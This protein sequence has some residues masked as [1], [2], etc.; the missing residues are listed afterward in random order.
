MKEVK[1]GDLFRAFGLVFEVKPS[2][3]PGFFYAE[4]I[5]GKNVSF[6]RLKKE[7]AE[8]LD[9]VDKFNTRFKADQIA[10]LRSLSKTGITL[11]EATNRLIEAGSEVA[12]TEEEDEY[13]Y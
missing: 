5:S 8:K 6:I 4:D 11:L 10:F 2:D 13:E 12:I 1:E 7:N 9:W 3:W